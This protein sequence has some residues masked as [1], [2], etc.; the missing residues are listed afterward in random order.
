[1]G[2]NVSEGIAC[3]LLQNDKT[4]NSIE[5]SGV[6]YSSDSYHMTNPHPEGEGAKNAM[7]N[8]LKCADIDSSQ[9]N[10]INAHGTGTFLGDNVE[11][12]AIKLSSTQNLEPLFS[13]TKG[14][15]GHAQGA[16][17]AF[18]REGFTR[19]DGGRCSIPF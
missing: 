5:L 1:M 17:G 18:I 4:E 6:G 11:T 15:H 9:I 2:M 8:A 19:C 7:E 10:Y 3:L 12:E 16:T 13:S 14:L